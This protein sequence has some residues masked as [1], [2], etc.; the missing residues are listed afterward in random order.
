MPW[1]H[2]EDKVSIMCRLDEG[3]KS[4]SWKDYSEGAEGCGLPGVIRVCN[5]TF[6]VDEDDSRPH[7]T[8]EFPTSPVSRRF[9]Q[10]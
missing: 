6:E 2:P 7:G 9:I 8:R 10:P 1:T 3:V 4:T 5:L